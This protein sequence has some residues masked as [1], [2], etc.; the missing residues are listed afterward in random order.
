MDHLEPVSDTLARRP[1]AT[2]TTVGDVV[3][4]AVL[5]AFLELDACDAAIGVSLSVLSA[6]SAGMVD[7]HGHIK[8]PVIC[9]VV[10][11]RGQ[12]I[13]VDSGIGNRPRPGWP[14]GRLD[15]ALREV[16][17]DRRDIEIV[18]KTH[19]HGDHVG[20]NTIGDD[21]QPAR[22]FFPNARYL[23]QQLEWDYWI[24]SGLA[25]AD[26][27]EHLRECVE[28]LAVGARVELVA[29]EIAVT[30][31]ITLVATPGHTP[32]HVAVGIASAGQR[33]LI[34]GDVTHYPAQLVHPDWSPAWDLDPRQAA[35]T[36]EGVFRSIENDPAASLLTSHW[37]YP[38]AGRIVAVAGRRQFLGIG[39]PSTGSMAPG[40]G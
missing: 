7:R 25:A 4:T 29:G 24:A 3:V 31:E 27:N 10:H 19:M 40:P 1:A 14:L 38:G 26:G 28:G 34:V 9:H 35:R 21:A 12:L 22:P 33:A 20:W 32:G 30:P 23:F 15:R 36:R 37:P 5:D 18:L 11:S 16:G 8:I 2:R 6:E 17:V 13:L 39:A